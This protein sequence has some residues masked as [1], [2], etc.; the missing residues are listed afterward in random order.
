MLMEH[1]E[2]QSIVKLYNTLART[3]LEFEAAWYG[4]WLRTLD[5]AKGGLQANL[6][7]RH[8]ASGASTGRGGYW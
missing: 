6:I 8:P 2:G 4:A 1:K 5:S 3:L 7:V